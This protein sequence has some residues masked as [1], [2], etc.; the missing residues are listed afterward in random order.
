M[1]LKLRYIILFIAAGWLLSSC[2]SAGEDVA[3]GTEVAFVVSDLSRASV[4][5]DLNYSDS[6]FAIYG[7]MRFRDNPKTKIF[8]NAIVRYK[9]DKWGYDYPQYWFP[10]HEHSF[11]AMHPVEHDGISAKQYSDSRLSFKYTLPDNYQDACDLMI[12][13]HRRMVDSIPNSQDVAPIALKFWHILS[14]VNFMVTNDAAADIVRVDKIVLE[15]VNKAGDFAI[16]PASLLSGS[17]QTD[18]YDFAWTGITNKSTLTANIS[19]EVPEDKERP[20]FPN[21]NALLMMPQPDNNDVIMHITYTLID[22]GAKNEQI[23]LTAQAPIGGWEPGKAYTYSLD[24][25][26]ITKEI[27]LTVSVKNWQTPKPT[28]VAV[29]EN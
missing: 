19:V 15:N 10:M 6:K 3:Q 28:E 23:T 12:A 14:R 13:T 9:Y 25:S 24:I 17:R 7:D 2:E 22:A 8:D 21:D 1:R 20:L 26:E 4:T 16:T 5:T 11:I 27:Y 29:P 18:D